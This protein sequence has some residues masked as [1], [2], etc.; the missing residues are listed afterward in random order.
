MN[1]ITLSGLI[2]N[3]RY[4]HNIKDVEYYKAELLV[5]RENGLEDLLNL[6]FK[7]FSCPYKENDKISLVGNIRTF[8]RKLDND[9][10]KVD[11]YVFTYFDIPEVTANNI[12]E[13]DG[14][15]C[16]K[17]DLRKTRT[18]KDV[19]DFIIANNISNDTSSLNCYLPVVAWGKQAKQISKLP[20]GS[21]I[22]IKGE[23]RS[24]E[25]K[26]QLD[27]GNFEIRIAHEVVV[28]EIL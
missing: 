11:I 2:R 9:K 27:N 1:K 14:K 26:K 15:I 22:N 3:I 13:L 16:K 7:R 10:S 21:V 17:G 8:S 6:K 12:V 23:L 24:R 5:E 4:S 18:G 20:V 19:I 28:K 25:Y